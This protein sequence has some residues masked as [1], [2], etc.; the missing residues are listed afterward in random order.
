M[1]I[2]SV[3]SFWSFGG[4]LGA[5][6]LRRGWSATFEVLC[7][8]VVTACLGVSPVHHGRIPVAGYDQVVCRRDGSLCGWLKD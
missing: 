3:R 8:L 6:D 2:L 7:I 5:A 4:V 1:L